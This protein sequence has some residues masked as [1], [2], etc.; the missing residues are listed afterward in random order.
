VVVPTH[1]LFVLV[2]YGL[3]LVLF[4][5]ELRRRGL[6]RDRG[7]WWIAFGAILGGTVG[8][9]VA[10]LWRYVGS[11]DDPTFVGVAADGGK[12]L[13][14]GLAGAYLGAVI[15]KRLIGHARST[16]DLFTPAVV[17]GIAVGRIGCFLTEQPGTP[18]E[19]PW[20]IRLDPGI[21]SSIPNCPQC[22]T[23]QSLHP[24]FLY[25][26]A[27]L[28]AMFL[29][30]RFLRPRVTVEGDLFKIFLASYAVFRFSVEFVRGNQPLWNGLSGT[31]LFLIPSSIVLVVYLVRQGWRGAYRRRPVAG[32][33]TVMS[34]S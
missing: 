17:G 11:V 6:V 3:A 33:I 20:G 25:E 19:L 29:L 28:V 23:G 2:G 14:G 24:S 31:Q 10:T 4:A 18:T 30:L 8:A 27:F 5:M 1:G 7:L 22:L 21:A 15:A 32:G 26:I 34:R 13:V 16:G 12:S 9:K